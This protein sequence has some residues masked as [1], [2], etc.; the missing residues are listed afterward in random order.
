MNETEIHAALEAERLSL[1]D[2][3]DDLDGADWA[4]TSLCPAWT[5]RDVVAHLTIPT[6]TTLL[7]MV[8]GML[9]AHGDFHRMTSRSASARAAAFTPARLTQ[10][11][12]DTAGSARRMPGGEPMD[13]LV[14]VLVHGQ[15]IARPL[16]RDLSMSTKPAATALAYVAENAFFGA[17]DHLAGLELVATDTGWTRAA[18]PDEVRGSTDAP[19][20]LGSFR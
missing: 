3:L 15:D 9:K 14:D 6:R 5:V 2:F 1:A 7:G 10:Q 11:L 13:P 8:F 4:V 12:R 19:A 16:E 20:R 17:P 18:G